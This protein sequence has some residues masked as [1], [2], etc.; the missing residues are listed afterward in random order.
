MR[1]RFCA[2]SLVLAPILVYSYAGRP[3]AQTIEKDWPRV[4][5][6]GEVKSPGVY[7]VKPPMTMKRALVVAGGTTEEAAPKQT[8]IFRK[9]PDGGRQQMIKVDLDALTAGRA[10][11]VPLTDDDVILVNRDRTAK[12]RNER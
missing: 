7:T 9:P 2:I 3:A 6:Y 8:V 10:E 5:V 4:F 11:D 12:P 1:L